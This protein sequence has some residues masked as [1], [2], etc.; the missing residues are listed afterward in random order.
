MSVNASNNQI[1]LK[2]LLEELGNRGLNDIFVEAGPILTGA[3]L[4]EGLIDELLVY[5]SPRLLGE[6]ARPMMANIHSES[7][8]LSPFLRL[9]EHIQ[10]DT[11][12]RL[13]FRSMI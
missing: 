12:I 13:R 5:V 6:Q 2:T 8:E 11:D 9:V 7:L 3:L 1:N 4:K 10:V